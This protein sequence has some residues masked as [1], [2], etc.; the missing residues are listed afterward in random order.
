MS[1]DH[2]II[3]GAGMAGLCAAVEASAAGAKVIVLEK[4]A[5]IGGSSLLSGCF[6]AFAETDFQKK[7]GIEDT[8]ESLMEDFLAV[9]HYKNKR[10]LIEAYGKHQLATYNWLVEQGV[11]FLTC[12]AV[13]G[14]SNPRGHTIIPGQAIGQLRA[15]AETTG[16]VIKTNAPVV[17]LLKDNEQVVGVVY[18]ENGEQ[19][20]L[21]TDYGVLL[22]AGG[23]SQSEELLA[24]FAPQL[25]NT[26]RLGG[27]GNKGDGIKL[28]ASAGAWLEDFTYLKGTYGF[29]PTSTND[30]K[31]QAH[32]FYKGGIIVNELGKRF[33]NESISYKLLGDA[34]LQQPN[35]RSYQVWD[36]TVM[37]KSVA[38]DALYD[39]ELLYR[40]GLIESFDTIEQLA[41]KAGLPVEALKQTISTYNS[42][43][44]KGQDTAFGRT[45]LTHKFGTPT[46][47]ET[48]PFYIME[49]AT[50]MLA[51]YA[52]VQ[53]DENGHVIDPFGEPIKGLFAAGEMVGGFHGAGYMTG[54]SLGKAAIFGR[55]AA[56]TAIQA[57]KQEVLK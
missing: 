3:V 2:L 8:T 30:K 54:S 17:R 48:A 56:R 20:E 14:H 40:E 41:E 33:V 32:T 25:A 21:T 53:V 49:T 15:N 5:E 26:V 4:Q 18:E 11:Q 51:T 9:G 45:S 36:Q 22:T 39:F 46:A 27:A 6:M 43:V 34:A 19:I 29:H 42:D 50:A 57:N 7:L 12:Q 38:N 10:T 1:R 37:D 23:F 44:K 16:A 13:S 52:G 28:A 35:C 47:I 24:Q 31:R 55:I